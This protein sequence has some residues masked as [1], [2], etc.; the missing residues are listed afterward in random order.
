MAA[1]AE[2]DIVRQ[3]FPL[4]A[5][6]HIAIAYLE[7]QRLKSIARAWG[8]NSSQQTYDIVRRLG[9]PARTPANGRGRKPTNRR[10]D[11]R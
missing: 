11:E 5:R 2:G 6:L 4:I 1:E 7:G 10:S 8:I 9:V 3:R